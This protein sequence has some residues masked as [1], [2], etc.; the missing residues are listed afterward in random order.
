MQFILLDRFNESDFRCS[1]LFL[2]CS[3]L[4]YKS[5]KLAS[6]AGI[7]QVVSSRCFCRARHSCR[8]ITC[9]GASTFLTSCICYTI[10]FFKFKTKQP[11]TSKTTLQHNRYSTFVVVVV[12]LLLLFCGQLNHLPW[13]EVLDARNLEEVSQNSHFTPYVQDN[14]DVSG[15]R[16][17]EPDGGGHGEVAG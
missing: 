17:E 12:V 16:T 11:V 5:C 7:V 1:F 14:P 6:H 9:S 3:S 13:A 2:F 8:E 10:D 4:Y 15:K